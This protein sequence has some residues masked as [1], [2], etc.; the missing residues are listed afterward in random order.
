MSKHKKISF[1]KSGIRIVGCLFGMIAFRPHFYPMHA[2]AF[3]LLAEVLGI[4]EEFY[5]VEPLV[6]GAMNPAQHRRKTDPVWFSASNQD[7]EKWPDMD[8]WKNGPDGGSF[9]FQIDHKD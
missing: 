2:F 5:E 6:W 3:L 4:V 7:P 9:G 1:V 8:S